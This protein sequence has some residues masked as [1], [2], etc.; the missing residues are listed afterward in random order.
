M[1]SLAAMVYFSGQPESGIPARPCCCA[2][3]TDDRGKGIGRFLSPEVA[4]EV[5]PYPAWSFAPGEID[6][7][8]VGVVEGAVADRQNG[9]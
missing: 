9:L 8:G 6:L 2:E 1:T 5:V 3:Q 7:G 4:S